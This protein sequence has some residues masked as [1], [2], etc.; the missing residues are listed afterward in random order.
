MRNKECPHLPTFVSLSAL[1]AGSASNWH[2]VCLQTP[3]TLL[4]CRAG[5][6]GLELGVRT[7]LHPSEIFLN[8]LNF[9]SFLFCTQSPSV[10]CVWMAGFR[11]KVCSLIL[12]I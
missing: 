4:A 12:A 10:A 6:R 9:L 8:F 11:S 7:T 2:G 3:R 5:T 1:P